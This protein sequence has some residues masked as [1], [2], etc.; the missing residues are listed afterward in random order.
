MKQLLPAQ[1]SI[2]SVS[3]I[4]SKFDA[5]PCSSQICT[6]TPLSKAA[7]LLPI[8]SHEDSLSLLLT[9][10]SA[11][12][13]EHASQICFPGGR[14][15]ESDANHEFTALRECEEEIS[16]AKNKVKILGRLSEIVTTTRFMITPIVGLIKAPLN[17]K[18]N[19]N[20]VEEIFEVPMEHFFNKANLKTMR[21]NYEGQLKSFQLYHYQ[22]YGIWGATARMIS[23]LVDFLTDTSL[24]ASNG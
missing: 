22:N 16:L 5:A 2:F 19:P 7:V 4:L 17:L 20:E 18:P 1:S 12:L 13:K 23:N 3:S 21:I 15:E 11:N 8:I 10:R 14:V 6:P 24:S 9:K